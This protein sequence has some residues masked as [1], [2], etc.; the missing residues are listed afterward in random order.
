MYRPHRGRY[1]ADFVG[2]CTR[3]T[4][5]SR[6]GRLE[7]EDNVVATTRTRRRWLLRWSGVLLLAWL[8]ACASSD[9]VDPSALGL[10]RASAPTG[11]PFIVVMTDPPG[12]ATAAMNRDAAADLAR[13]LGVHPA[14]T[15]GTVLVGF[16]AEVPEGRKQAIEN[17]PRVAY[18]APD[19]PVWIMSTDDPFPAPTGVRR[20]FAHANA[21][22]PISTSTESWVDV[23]V[24]VLDTGI[25]FDHPDLNVAEGVDCTVASGGGPPWARTYECRD[26]HGTGGDDDHY[27]GTHVAGTIAAFDGSGNGV[28]GV[29]PGARLWAVKVLDRNGSGSTSGIIAGIEWVVEKGIPIANM[30]LGGSGYNQP[31]HEAIQEAVEA[32]VAFAVSAGNSSADAGSFSPAQFAEVLTVSALADFDGKPGGEGAPTCRNDDDDTLANFSNY[33]AAVDIAAPG[34][35][36]LSTYP[37]SQGGYGTISGTSMAAPH[38]AGAL[39]LLVSSEGA[40]S[41]KAGVEAFYAVLEGAGNLD[42]NDT[43]GDGV[44]EPLLDVRNADAFEPKTIPASGADPGDPPENEAPTAS[45]SYAC[46]DLSCSF[47][48]SE[49]SGPDGTTYGWDFGDRQGGTGE[50]VE[51]KY[52]AAGTFT[53]TL[54]LTVTDD[55]GATATDTTSKDVTV[56]DPGDFALSVN[57]YKVRGVKHADL[58]WSGATTTSVDIYRND[59]DGPIDVVD[60]DGSYTDEIATRGGGSYT[61]QVC[62]AGTDTCSNEATA[63]F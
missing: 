36:I 44:H 9:A 34:V 1:I 27:H 59:S 51:H 19:A 32:G 22:I 40:P 28:V 31:M 14:R 58:S 57:A 60:N 47:D 25:A 11:D 48:G 16:A 2:A 5:E 53:V 8:V 4:V 42:W 46:E 63:V 26:D 35:C 62:E 39:A 24:A 45:F 6:C 20:I 21:S 13:A 23:D 29:A 50:T 38:A 7:T 17:H 61:Y 15:F 49:S 41:G 3:Q 55:D 37:L 54:T 52:A 43:S 56:G 10:E 30:S 12:R 33:G 18:V